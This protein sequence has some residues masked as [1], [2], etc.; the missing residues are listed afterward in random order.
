MN[1]LKLISAFAFALAFAGTSFAADE[2]II[3]QYG[4]I[5]IKQV[6]VE[7]ADQNNT[8]TEVTVA[9]IDDESNETPVITEDIKVDSVYYSRVF[10]NQVPSTLMLPFELKQADWKLFG[11]NVFEFVKI[12]ESTSDCRYQNCEGEGKYVVQFREFPTGSLKA[13]T[14]YIV[15]AYSEEPVSFHMRYASP[16]YVLLNTTTNERFVSRV[17]ED[18]KWSFID[19]YE[20]IKFTDSKGIYGFAAKNKNKTKIGEFTK[21]ACSEKSCAY[22]RPFR[23]YLRCTK[24]KASAVNALAKS[25]DDAV[26]SLDNLPETIDVQII[27]ADSSRTYLGTLNT[28]TGEITVDDRWFDMKGRR[29]QQKPT[30]KGTYFNN[31]K[32]VVIK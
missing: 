17:Y 6:M 30:A 10:K 1:K 3:G 14:P 24:P 5:T 16:E 7:N 26:A 28:Y 11:L 12:T 31:K 29:L 21:A 20:Y 27:K 4:A 2:K 32:K 23:A 15:V 18:L 9:V 8:M 25:A 19:T 13:N 22:I